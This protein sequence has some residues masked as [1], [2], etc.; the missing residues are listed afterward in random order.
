MELT[1]ELLAELRA[2]ARAAQAEQ[3]GP[4][5]VLNVGDGQ[6]AWIGEAGCDFEDGETFPLSVVSHVCAAHP[7]VVL[8]LLDRVEGQRQRAEAAE[9][10]IRELD[11]H[12]WGC[13]CFSCRCRHPE[14]YTRPG[15]P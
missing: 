15:E 8:A 7:A 10:C 3:P 4:W 6:R 5:T 11:S 9:A 2:K 12:V 13:G 14:R 1:P